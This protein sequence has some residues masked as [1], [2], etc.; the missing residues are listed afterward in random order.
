V[1]APASIAAFSIFFLQD[2]QLPDTLIEV[3]VCAN[4]KLQ[5][6]KSKESIIKFFFIVVCLFFKNYYSFHVKVRFY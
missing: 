6:N 4:A 5:V 3:G 1:V 2:P